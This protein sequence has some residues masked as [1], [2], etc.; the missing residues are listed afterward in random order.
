MYC[1]CYPRC[2]QESDIICDGNVMDEG[3]MLCRDVQEIQLDKHVKLLDS[4]GVI[5]SKMGDQASL[6]LRNCIKLENLTDPIPA[7]EAILRQ[8]NKLQVS[9]KFVVR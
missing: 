9:K 3:T 1:G 5:M 7:I 2:Y 6:I 8:C 4:P